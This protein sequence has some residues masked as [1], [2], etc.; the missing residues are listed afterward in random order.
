MATKLGKRKPRDILFGDDVTIE[1]RDGTTT[2]YSLF[3]LRNA[4]PCASCVEEMTGRKTLD[5]KSI[6]ADIHIG[7]A[8]YVGHYGIR[9][10]WSDGHNTG[11]YS[12]AFLREMA[13]D[14]NLAPGVT[15]VSKPS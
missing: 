3:T 10:N 12:F 15:S 14:P 6:P 4:C 7:K 1:W 11:I 13:D 2:H 8:E 9:I 5:P